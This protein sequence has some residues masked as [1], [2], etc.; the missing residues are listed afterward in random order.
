M[1]RVLNNLVIRVGERTLY[2]MA[3]TIRYSAKEV[4][5]RWRYTAK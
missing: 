4:R 5:R 1:E 2:S 3:S